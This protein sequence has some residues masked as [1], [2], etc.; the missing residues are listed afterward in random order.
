M[1]QAAAS[2]NVSGA[3][4]RHS[5]VRQAVPAPA[6]YSWAEAMALSGL[7]RR[8][9]RSAICAGSFPAP[10]VLSPGRQGFPRGEVDAW[11]RTR[12]VA[13]RV[14]MAAVAGQNLQENPT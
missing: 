9:L 7:G 12:P 14:A 13:P 1:L 11:A 6:F 10:R 8:A 4:V 2:A 3:P 5:R